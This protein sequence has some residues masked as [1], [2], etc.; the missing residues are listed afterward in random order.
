MRRLSAA[1]ALA[2]FAAGCGPFFDGVGSASD[3]IADAVHAAAE[4]G[5][6][7]RLADVTDF[8]WDR[9]YVVGPY[10]S[11]ENADKQLGFHW[12]HAS[13][14]DY[15]MSDGGSLLVFV[16]DGEVVRAYDQ[17]NGDGIFTCVGFR[18]L[19][20]SQASLRVKRELQ[21][22]EGEIEKLDFVLPVGRPPDRRC[23][24]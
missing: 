16:R 1:V 2:L 19:T 9:F 24:L 13:N 4:D 18:G 22:F 10:F 23:S 11:Q 8:E 3:D 6:T 12:S 5:S 15:K 14:S 17:S 20:P 21:R 7:F